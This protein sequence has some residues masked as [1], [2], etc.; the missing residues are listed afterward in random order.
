MHLQV[1]GDSHFYQQARAADQWML[2]AHWI[3]KFPQVALGD[4]YETKRAKSQRA[5]KT[6]EGF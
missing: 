6:L 5:E 4:G 1:G 3:Q 2:P